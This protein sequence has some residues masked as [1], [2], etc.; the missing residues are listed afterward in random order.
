[1]KSTVLPS[2]R[3]DVPVLSL[4]D[5]IPSSFID[6]VNLKAAVSPSLPQE[7]EFNPIWAIPFKKVPIDNIIA[8]H[9]IFSPIFSTTDLTLPSFVSIL[10]TIP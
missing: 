8:S 4:P 10:S 1:M 5:N 6:S 9:S 2:I 3:G 7:K